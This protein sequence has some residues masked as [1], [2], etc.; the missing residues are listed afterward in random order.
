M[1][2]LQLFI[3]GLGQAFSPVAM[4]YI[5]AGIIWGIIGGATPG[6]SASIAMALALP[7]TFGICP[8][9]LPTYGMSPCRRDLMQPV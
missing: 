7:F 9:V 8:T 3:Q 5:A 6:I 1:N 4:L 2:P